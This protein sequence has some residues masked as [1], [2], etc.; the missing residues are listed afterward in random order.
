MP[1]LAHMLFAGVMAVVFIAATTCMVS[2]RSHLACL[3]L[4]HQEHAPLLAALLMVLLAT[5]HALLVAISRT[6]NKML[7]LLPLLPTC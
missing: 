4:A 5:S 6:L 2:C 3:H 1:H 7:S